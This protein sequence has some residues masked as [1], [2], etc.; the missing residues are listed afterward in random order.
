MNRFGILVRT[1]IETMSDE[2]GDY[3]FEDIPAGEYIVKFIW[4]EGENSIIKTKQGT[5][6]PVKIDKY[7]STPWSQDNKDEKDYFNDETQIYNWYMY[8]ML[9][10]KLQIQI[11]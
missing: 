1:P 5:E 11:L 2:N 7:N 6:K 4:G 10:I 9:K 3:K 8:S